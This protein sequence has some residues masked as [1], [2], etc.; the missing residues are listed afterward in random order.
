MNPELFARHIPLNGITGEALQALAGAFVER[1]LT[2]GEALFERGGHRG[3]LTIVLEGEIELIAPLGGL[4]VPMIIFQPFDIISA[5]SLFEHDGIHHQS[6][7]ARSDVARVA[8]ITDQDYQQVLVQHPSIERALLAYIISV[9]DDRLD[10]ANRKLLSL[11]A[12]G[13]ASMGATTHQE[14]GQ[15]IAPLLGDTLRCTKVALLRHVVGKW[16]IAAS[17]G[18]DPSSWAPDLVKQSDEVLEKIV[19]D[20]ESQWVLGSRATALPEYGVHEM[21]V[22][23]CYAN[24]RCIGALLIADREGGSFS[25]NTILHMETIARIVAGGFARL[26]EQEVMRGAQAAKQHFVQPFT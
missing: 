16:I 14:L 4:Q 2:R 7:H 20:Q 12:V 6:A 25:V 1:T 23:G 15:Q 9:L 11:V 22:T 19:H 5:R 10:H 3:E 26:D 8:Q 18:F 24:N 17:H 21:I 13:R